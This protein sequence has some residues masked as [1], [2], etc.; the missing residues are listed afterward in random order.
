MIRNTFEEDMTY[1]LL[2]KVNHPSYDSV[3]LLESVSTAKKIL[4]GLDRDYRLFFKKTHDDIRVEFLEKQAFFN[5]NLFYLIASADGNEDNIGHSQLVSRYSLMLAKALG[6]HDKDFLMNIESGAALHDIGKICI[7]ERILR[8]PGALTPGER[9]IVQD[10][11]LLGYELIKD[12][13]FLND[14]SQIVLFHHE[15]YDGKGYPFGLK[16]EYIPLEARIFSLVDAL[17]AITSDRPYREAQGFRAAVEE[18]EKGK[19]TQFDPTVVDAF[20]SVPLMKWEQIKA[21]TEEAL[22]ISSTH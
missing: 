18:I 3:H 17:D 14:T 21:E 4:R 19:G 11:P 12:Y 13:N 16:G 8:K 10:H 7:P 22:L 15:C 1:Q 5:S 20:L 9:L 2:D 6:I